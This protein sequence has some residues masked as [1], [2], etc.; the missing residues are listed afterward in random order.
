MADSSPTSLATNTDAP[1][2]LRINLGELS[3]RYALVFAWIAVAIVFSILRPNTFATWSNA[4]TILGS[5]SVLVVLTLGLILPLT[6]GEFDLSVGSNLAFSSV[7][8]AVLNV[9]HHWPIVPAVLLGVAAS[10]VVG[11]VNGL[12]VV[13]VGLDSVI[14]TVAMS[15]L[16]TGLALGMTNFITVGG[17]SESLVHVI[18]NRALGIPL[19]F[20]YGIGLG[21]IVWYVFRFTP[22]GRHLIF[23]GRGRDVARLS[24]LPVNGIR[25]GAFTAAGLFA[26]LAGVI[27]AGT[28]GAAD[29]NSGVNYL[30][31]AFSAAF[32]GSTV[33]AP[34][35]F[36]P[37]GSIIAVYFLVTAITGLELL[38]LSSWIE[39]VF[40]GTALGLAVT[41]S[42]LAARKRTA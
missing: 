8:V 23:V 22:L 13:S 1:R 10:V 21:M 29:P 14:A 3:Y 41:L 19:S 26:G 9:N 6:V 40:Y 11:L 25:I 37:W 5:Q 15:T 7:I 39:Q 31:P 27:L 2:V 24:G 38:G 42:R 4:T 33:V 17:V 36:N 28:L 32:L 16:L 34:G 20:Y 30:L 12:L 18:S 35:F